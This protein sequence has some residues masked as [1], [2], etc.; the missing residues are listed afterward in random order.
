MPCKPELQAE[1]KQPI[2]MYVHM[3]QYHAIEIMQFL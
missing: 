2:C 1:K 3:V